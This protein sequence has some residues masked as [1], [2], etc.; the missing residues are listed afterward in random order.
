MKS[1]RVYRYLCLFSAAMAGTSLLSAQVN[2]DVSF[3]V[4]T[5][6]ASASSQSID[7]F[8]DGTFYNTPRLAGAFGKI[9]GDLMLR[10]SL[11]VGAEYSFR[12]A[13]GAYAGLGYRPAFY[14]INAV[15]APKLHNKRIQPEFQAGLGGMDLKFY[16]NQSACDSFAGCSSSNTYVESSQ[17]FQ[18]HGL[19]AV[20]FYVTPHIFIRPEAEVHWVNNLFQ[21]GNGWV[22]QYGASV[23]YTFGER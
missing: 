22:P 1:F 9:S 16:E 3:G 14:D 13:Q 4:G 15:Y 2:G 18:L 6:T 10:G 21:F 8:G 19:A 7:T 23:G 20:R 5:A 17:H 12:F 11:G